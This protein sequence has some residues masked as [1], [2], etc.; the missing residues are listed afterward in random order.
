MKKT[1]NDALV[2]E[3]AKRLRAG[4]P[5]G[6]VFP[7][8]ISECEFTEAQKLVIKE[9]RKVR[10]LVDEGGNRRKVGFDGINMTL[11]LGQ[12]IERIGVGLRDMGH[13]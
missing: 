11:L 3:H 9:A 1:V 4:G 5:L 13:H 12:V 7:W 6:E 8:P 10:A 2:A